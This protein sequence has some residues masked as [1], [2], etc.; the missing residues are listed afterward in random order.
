[1][2]PCL[3]TRRI[4]AALLPD[5]ISSR[6]AAA[7][8]DSLVLE[9]THRC[10]ASVGVSLL[11]WTPRGAFIVETRVHQALKRVYDLKL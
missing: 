7:T 4:P 9:V 3:A 11:G 5:A 6:L 2:G 1:M 8:G 10:G